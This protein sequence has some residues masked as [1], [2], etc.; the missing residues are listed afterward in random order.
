MQQLALLYDK[1]LLESYAG[2]II[3]DPATAIEVRMV[4]P[5]AGSGRPTPVFASL[6]QVASSSIERCRKPYSRERGPAE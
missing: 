1:W 2:A 5:D 6:R 3:T 4:W